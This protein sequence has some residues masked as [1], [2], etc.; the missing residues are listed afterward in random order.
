MDMVHGLVYEHGA[1]YVV[2]CMKTY[3][4]FLP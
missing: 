4:V 1:L 3:I 2:L